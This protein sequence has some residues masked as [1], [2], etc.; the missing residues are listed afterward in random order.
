MTQP[1]LRP[2]AEQL[3]R[4]AQWDLEVLDDPVGVFFADRELEGQIRAVLAA[5]WH[6]P[7]HR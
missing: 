2:L 4:A 1:E 3:A 6:P 7:A 5:G